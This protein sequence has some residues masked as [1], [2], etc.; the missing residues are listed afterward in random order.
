MSNFYHVYNARYDES[1]FDP[2]Q[3]VHYW[4]IVYTA[5]RDSDD[6][7]TQTLMVCDDDLG[8]DGP[9]GYY[10]VTGDLMPH[11]RI[12]DLIRRTLADCLA[13]E[14]GSWDER[15]EA[16]E[17]PA[18]WESVYNLSEIKYWNY[19]DSTLKVA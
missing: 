13:G 10:I 9:I 11:D 15:D 3:K 17:M 8:A 4:N 14:Y 16:D 1:Q 6:S 18:F 12:D 2:G 7:W 5:I 19:M